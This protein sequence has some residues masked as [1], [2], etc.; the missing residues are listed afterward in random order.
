MLS[1]FIINADVSTKADRGTIR[2][3]PE[4]LLSKIFWFVSHDFLLFVALILRRIQKPL[5]VVEDTLA[6]SV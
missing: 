5:R 3:C 4:L 2:E 6:L 1:E